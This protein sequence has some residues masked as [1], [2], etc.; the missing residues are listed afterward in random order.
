MLHHNIMLIKQTGKEKKSKPKQQKGTDLE[1]SQ[2]QASLFTKLSNTRAIIMTEHTI[3]KDGISNIWVSDQVDLQNLQSIQ[4]ET[5][6]QHNSIKV[7]EATEQHG[8]AKAKGLTYW[9]KTANLGL[10]KSML[11]Q[12]WL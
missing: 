3:S 6:E 12:V 2:V 1:S 5:T 8:N 7:K 4:T 9:E 11:R 10:K